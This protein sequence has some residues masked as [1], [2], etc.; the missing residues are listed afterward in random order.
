M[1]CGHRKGMKV[2]PRVRGRDARGPASAGARAAPWPV[3]A[4]L[5]RNG[6]LGA[7][8]IGRQFAPVSPAGSGVPQ[9]RPMERRHPA[10][11]PGRTASGGDTTPKAQRSERWLTSRTTHG[12]PAFAQLLKNGRLGALRI[13]R[14]FAPVSPAGSGAPQARP[15]ERRHPAGGPCRTANGG[16]TTP[17]ALRSERWLTSRTTHGRPAFAQLLRNGRLGALRVG[18]Q[19][20]PVSS[21]ARRR[22]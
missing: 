13:G 6:R 20:A 14:Q 18:R 1:P 22:P 17:K 9:A 8:R 16:D 5:L 3:S 4:R 11:G 7:L 10:G 15:M 12:R 21:R 19:F 2:L